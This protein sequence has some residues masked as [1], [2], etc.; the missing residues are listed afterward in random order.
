M[1]SLKTMDF[2]LDRLLTGW[3]SIVIRL[4]WVIL[5]AFLAGSGLSLHYTF[6]NLGVNTNTEDMLSADLPFRINH[7]RLHKA[8]PQDA[9]TILVVIES[10]IPE[11]SNNATQKLGQF[12][13]SEPAFVKSVY[14]P[15]EDQFFKHHAL[16]YE[17][18][19]NLD[20]LAMEITRAQPFLG[21]LARNNSLSEYASI[22]GHAIN[23]SAEQS[24]LN[25]D[26]IL[27]DTTLAIER[28]RNGDANPMSWQK[29]MLG[30]QSGLNTQQRFILIK[31]VFNYAE[32][33]PAEPSFKFVRGIANKY[34]KEHP[35]VRIRLTGEVAL[36]HEELESISADM[37]IAGITSLILVCAT[38]LCALHSVRLAIITVISLVTGLILSAGFATVAVGH[39]N[40]ISIAFAVLYV[41]LGVDYALHLSL[42]YREFINAILPTKK[43]ITE[44]VRTV[45]PS[46]LLCTVTTSIGFFA[47]IPTAYVGVSELGL[48]SG[49]AMFIGLF[50]SLTLLPA[51]LHLMPITPRPSSSGWLNLPNW[52]Y[53]MPEKSGRAIRWITLLLLL[54]ALG[55]IPQVSF[56]F[57]PIALRDPNSES[58]ATFRD[59]LQAKENSPLTISMVTPDHNASE[60]IIKR[61]EKLD[62]VDRV[63]NIDSFI[64]E[65]QEEKLD[66]LANLEESLGPTLT[67]FPAIKHD[68]LGIQTRALRKLRDIVEAKIANTPTPEQLLIL[69]TLR[70]NLNNF[71]TQL[72]SSDDDQKKRLLATL[73]DNL[74]ANLPTAINNLISA[75][76]AA[77]LESYDQLPS[78]LRDR[79]ISQT[80]D[81][82]IQVFPSKNLNNTNNL[83]EFVSQVQ[84]VAPNS[85]DL[86][87][88]YAESGKEV[89]RA[90]QQA[91]GNA[92]IA[93]T[94]ITFLVFR[95][96]RLTAF[97]L[98]PLFLAGL[99]TG[100]STVISGIPFNFANIIAIPLLLG[101]G[102]D[103]SIHVVHRL[104][105]MAPDDR[106]ILETSTAR[107][108]F[109]SS[110]TTAVSFTSLA[111]ISHAGTASLGQLLTIAIAVTLV[112]TLIILPAFAVKFDP[113]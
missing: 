51:L 101:L 70:D 19:D 21:R 80:G 48:I 109:F 63:V 81:Y 15:G 28:A 102:V 36:E 77:P 79:W 93:I 71:L 33:V 84:Q 99:L 13:R 24:S 14:I 98:L 74:L 2:L 38:L 57:D 95:S 6:N 106:N 110:L 52:F 58:V 56:D 37:T 18:V 87:V 61:L 46:I 69:T 86:P 39:L 50:V 49:V 11:Q 43:A 96:I 34:E 40:L 23:N 66:I 92:V 3:V 45:G 7:A 94:V 89:L 20:Q 27:S 29:L 10:D 47:F 16:L 8:F 25:L 30:T 41:G 108:V 111:F 55:L 85:T 67:E 17:D 32:M 97:V 65:D 35:G 12:F 9:R 78:S 68:P 73:S 60:E 44:G 31:P 5:L 103:S 82:R 100:A 26:T 22:L 104:R 88:I 90:F 76:L 64:P 105:H 59:L 4:R 72:N 62:S 53:Q 83:R 54:L 75:L 1:P 107:G 113:A 42:R 112:C 91:L